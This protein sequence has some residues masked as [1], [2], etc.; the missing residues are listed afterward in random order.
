MLT[1]PVYFLK[2]GFLLMFGVGLAAGARRLGS[3]GSITGES[4][5]FFFFSS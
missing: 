1:V 2:C 5:F 4:T 3:I